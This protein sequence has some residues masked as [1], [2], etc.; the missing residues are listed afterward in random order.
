MKT[1]MNEPTGTPA[2][3]LCAACGMCCNGVLFH[4]VQVHA[5]DSLRTLAAKGLKAKRRDG[6]LQFSQPCPAHRDSCCTI[7]QDRPRR[8]RDFVCRQLDAVLKG[9]KTEAAALEK[10][11]E[12][13]VLTEE[14]YVLLAALGDTRDHRALSVRCAGIFT[15]P[16]DDS[17]GATALRQSLHLAMEKL[18]IL[19]TSDFR[20][21]VQPL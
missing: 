14:I 18:E 2:G 8:C 12:C 11:R 17:H 10:I 20:P 6:K 15:P 7:Y 19:L 16:F 3:R 5:E 13:R 4:G 9:E 1:T 21:S